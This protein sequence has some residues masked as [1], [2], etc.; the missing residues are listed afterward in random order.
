M[1]PLNLYQL[2]DAPGSFILGMDTRFFDIY[3]NQPTTVICID[4]DT[5]TLSWYFSLNLIFIL[6]IMINIRFIVNVKNWNIRN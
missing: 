5:N 3:P 6:K 4:L 2:V 1:C